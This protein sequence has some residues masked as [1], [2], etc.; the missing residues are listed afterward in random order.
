M[1]ISLLL[2]TSAGQKSPAATKCVRYKRPRTGILA[3]VFLAALGFHTNFKFIGN[4]NHAAAQAP[5]GGPAVP[6][7]VVASAAKQGDI[8]VYLTGL[9]TVTALYTATILPQVTGQILQVPFKE[10]E[11][12]KKGALLVQIDPRPFEA[13][14]LQAQ[15]QL[16]RDKAQL[17]EARVDFKRFD[18]LAKQDSIALQQRDDQLYLVQQLEGTVKLDEGLV[19]AAK[20]NLEY[21]RITCPFTG[22]VGLRLVDPGNVVYTP[23]TTGIAVITQEQPITVIF[24]VPEDSLPSVLEKMRAGE[25]LPVDVFNR[26]QTRRISSGYLLTTD[27]IADTSTGTVRLKAEFANK[28]NALFPNQFVNARVL[29]ETMHGVT[30]VPSFAIQTSPQGKFVYLV[31]EN[32]TVSVRPVKIGVYEG[33]T[34]SIAEGVS[35]GDLVVVRGAERLKEG[36]RVE[37]QT[38][39]SDSTGKDGK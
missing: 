38:Q 31:N 24:P 36:S 13:A 12:L 10:G 33:E 1:R 3:I 4:G 21:T 9:G 34:V 5:A 29:M 30:L 7:P 16:E 22:R 14:L 26:E 15:G 28:D 8:H 23:D 20:V 39:G 11:V 18:T 32:R 27:N 19:Q 37:L 17:E 25:R 35:P 2:E 6:V